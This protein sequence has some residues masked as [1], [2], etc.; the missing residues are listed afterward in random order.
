MKITTGNRLENLRRFMKMTQE[1]FGSELGVSG[2]TISTYERDVRGLDDQVRTGLV[3]KYGIR[4]E[5]LNKG[6]GNMFDDRSHVNDMIGVYIRLGEDRRKEY[7]D[8][9]RNE[10]EH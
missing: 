10:L 9:M 1:E 7:Y 8:M 6:E 3:D 4:L 2:S 5:W